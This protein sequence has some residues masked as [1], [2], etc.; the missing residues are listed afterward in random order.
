MGVPAIV[1]GYVDTD[2]IAPG[3]VYADESVI[4]QA[5]DQ[6]P[7]SGS[8]YMDIPGLTVSL[9]LARPAGVLQIA[10]VDFLRGVAFGSYGIQLVCVGHPKSPKAITRVVA[11]SD[12]WHNLFMV[13]YWDSLAAGTHTFKVQGTAGTI[14]NRKNI[15][16][17]MRI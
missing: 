11:Y 3:T 2:A 7:M 8:G 17:V 16:L 1:A 15:L 4:A 10:Q 9:S 13:M 5:S 6:V 12:V 14:K